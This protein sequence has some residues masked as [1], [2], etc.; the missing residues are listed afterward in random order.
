M[1]DVD[2]VV[3]GPLTKKS[4]AEIVHDCNYDNN[5]ICFFSRAGDSFVGLNDES[6]L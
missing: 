1:D 2:C 3:T 4:F 5:H 6:A